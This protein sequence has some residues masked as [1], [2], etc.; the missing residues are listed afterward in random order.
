LCSPLIPPW[1]CLIRSVP[2]AEVQ[3]VEEAGG[4]EA[5]E[6]Q[7]AEEQEVEVKAERVEVRV[8][9]EREVEVRAERAEEQ[10]AEVKAEVEVGRAVVVRVGERAAELRIRIS[11]IPRMASRGPS[12]RLFP[13]QHPRISR[14]S[15]LL[16]MALVDSTFSIPTI[17]W[18]DSIK[19]GASKMNFTFWDTRRE[20][21]LKAVATPSK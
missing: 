6:V 1:P 4:P 17:Y 9:E 14:C 3:E 11:T 13:L 15:L 5:E 7:V 16:P 10:E 12:C 2:A 19:L 20:T 18:E 8:V 21:P